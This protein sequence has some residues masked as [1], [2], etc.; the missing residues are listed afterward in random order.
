MIFVRAAAAI[1]EQA[2]VSIDAR[3]GYPNAE[4]LTDTAIPPA[5]FL[6]A[7]SFGRVYAALPD[8][9]GKIAIPLGVEEVSETEYLTAVPPLPA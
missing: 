9:L 5:A 7:D 3:M 8:D 4:T 1:Y 2:R 6:P